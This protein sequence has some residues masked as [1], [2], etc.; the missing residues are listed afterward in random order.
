[1]DYLL[2]LNLRRRTYLGVV[3]GGALLAGC[4][5]GGDDAATPIETGD[6]GFSPGLD[7]KP[8]DQ[9]TV[10][11]YRLED[12]VKRTDVR[13][14]YSGPPLNSIGEAGAIDGNPDIDFSPAFHRI[15]AV[16]TSSHANPAKPPAPA[17]I[18]LTSRVAYHFYSTLVV[19]HPV[20]IV[21]IGVPYR[22]GSTRMLFH[23]C[24][25][26]HVARFPDEDSSIHLGSAYLQGLSIEYVG[27][28]MSGAEHGVIFNRTSAITRC[29]IRNFPGHGLHVQATIQ[30]GALGTNASMSHVFMCTVFDCGRSGVWIQG[31]DAQVMHLENTNSFS[32]G[33]QK[34]DNDGYGFY[35]A[36]MLGNTYTACHTRNNYIAGYKA[37]N[38]APGAPNRS[39]YINCYT[40]HGPEPKPEHTLEGPALLG[41]NALVITSNGDGNL[42]DA[43][44]GASVISTTQGKL[45]F[46]DVVEVLGKNGVSTVTGDATST[47]TPNDGVVRVQSR[48]QSTAYGTAN[49]DS[50]ILFQVHDPNPIVRA[51]GIKSLSPNTPILFG[52]TD[53]KHLRPSL[54]IAPRGLLIGPYFNRTLADDNFIDGARRIGMHDPRKENELTQ[55]F[56]NALLGDVVWSSI[57]NRGAYNF[58]GWIYADNST[59]TGLS[60]QRAW[61]RFGEGLLG[62]QVT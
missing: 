27:S 61:F 45:Q 44:G 24:S 39:T 31:K 13:P 41:A 25:G 14:G 5:G 47:V 53:R 58:R 36:S 20:E 51:W 1:M 15:M 12:F 26:I 54:P 40:E 38:Y 52:L 3:L 29:S 21:G 11:E 33:R 37:D 43:V 34:I 49:V 62:S 50:E 16:L 57:V 30:P 23:S 60:G 9:R 32:N 8:I 22:S 46:K 10:M 28:N 42:A 7:E 35:D 4:G 56:P 19:N 48:I 17:R 6:E 2:S 59:G 18:T 55:A